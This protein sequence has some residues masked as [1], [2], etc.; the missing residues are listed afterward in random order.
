MCFELLATLPALFSSAAPAAGAAGAA[1]ASALPAVG[2]GTAGMGAGLGATLSPFATEAAMVNA[3]VIP[4]IGGAQGGSGLLGN[5]GILGTTIG[6]GM[7]KNALAGGENPTPARPP[8]QGRFS[9][10]ASPEGIRSVSPRSLGGFIGGI[11]QDPLEIL[12][13][14]M[15]MRGRR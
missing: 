11:N 6:G 13:R 14:Q 2:A 8:P 4:A 10:P 1:G 9:F 12:R 3:G 15:A 7:L 5:L